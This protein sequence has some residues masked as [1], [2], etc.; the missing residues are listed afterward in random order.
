[1]DGVTGT[2]KK[3]ER[4]EKKG[5]NNEEEAVVPKCHIRP[6]DYMLRNATCDDPVGCGLW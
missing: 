4:E 6:E 1:M 2:K 5:E 3:H